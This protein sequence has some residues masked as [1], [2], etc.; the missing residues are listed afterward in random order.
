LHLA[1]PS[2]CLAPGLS[3]SLGLLALI[4]GITVVATRRQ[5]GML[6]QDLSA[7]PGLLAACR[8]GILATCAV[9]AIHRRLMRRNQLMLATADQVAAPHAQQRL[10]QHR[11]ALGVVIAQ[12]G[13]VQTALLLALDDGHPLAL[14]GDL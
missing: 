6:G 8:R 2:C 9:I 7:L 1:R 10:A 12:E 13:L 5:A 3:G 4:P 11:P 14:V